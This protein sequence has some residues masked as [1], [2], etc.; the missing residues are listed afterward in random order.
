MTTGT[1][2][3]GRQAL[4]FEAGRNAYSIGGAGEREAMTA[5]ELRRL[6]ED[7]DDDT[8]IILS[9]DRGYTYGSLDR[10]PSFMI[11]TDGEW[12]EA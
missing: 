6:L 7:Y 5:G 12:T 2:A 8:L 11:E 10:R 1:T 4:V 3:K 9:H